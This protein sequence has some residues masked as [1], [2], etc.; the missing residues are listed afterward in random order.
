M[1]WSFRPF[2]LFDNI[3]TLGLGFF[4][5]T[6]NIGWIE[7]EAVLLKHT[8]EETNLDR[9]IF[10]TLQEYPV[11]FQEPCKSRETFECS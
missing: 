4:F 1:S 8:L 2:C 10:C 5:Q 7:S 9:L 6:A 3:Q 11:F